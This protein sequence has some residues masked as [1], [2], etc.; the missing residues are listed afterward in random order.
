MNNHSFKDGIVIISSWINGKVSNDKSLTIL[1]YS[2]KT[3]YY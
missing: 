2:D 1:E 3:P